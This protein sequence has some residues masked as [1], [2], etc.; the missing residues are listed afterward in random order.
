MHE[1]EQMVIELTLFVPLR[2]PLLLPQLLLQV[3]ILN[4][5]IAHLRNFLPPPPVNL[6]P[7]TFDHHGFS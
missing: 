5:L 6:L 7:L 2:L 3:E 1:P 4:F